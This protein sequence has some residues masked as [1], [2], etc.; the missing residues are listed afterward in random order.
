VEVCAV[1]GEHMNDLRRRAIQLR[2]AEMRNEMEV[3]VQRLA[4]LTQAEY[5]LTCSG[6][7]CAGLFVT[8]SSWAAGQQFYAD[9]WRIKNEKAVCKQCGA[10]VEEVKG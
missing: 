7:G 8:T 4:L 1:Y 10:T 6:C 2:N 5:R 3:T 9:G